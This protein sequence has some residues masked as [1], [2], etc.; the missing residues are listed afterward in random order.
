MMSVGKRVRAHISALEQRVVENMLNAAP[1]ET[2]VPTSSS[3]NTIPPA[4][5]ASSSSSSPLT[6]TSP[7]S[8]YTAF[9]TPMGSVASGP[10][11]SGSVAS[12][13][14]ASQPNLGIDGMFDFMEFPQTVDD[15]CSSHATAAQSWDPTSASS[16]G[17]IPPRCATCYG[18]SRSHNTNTPRELCCRFHADLLHPCNRHVHPPP[19]Q[20]AGMCG[21]SGEVG[22]NSRDPS[23]GH[24]HRPQISTTQQHFNIPPSTHIPS[25]SHCH[26]HRHLPWGRPFPLCPEHMSMRMSPLLFFTSA[27]D[28]TVDIVG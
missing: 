7:T 1:K 5:L 27:S 23:V 20:D 25:F 12:G 8:Q 26:N 16:C 4:S 19:W 9:A 3:E 11:A 17:A 10:V 18:V 14:V 28:S 6:S 13:P 2:S 15:T 24:H 22:A 21:Y